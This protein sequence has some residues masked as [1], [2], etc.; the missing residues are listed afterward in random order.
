MNHSETPFVLMS[1]HEDFF[2]SL[3]NHILENTAGQAQ[4]AVVI[5]PHN[6]PKAYLIHAFREYCQEHGKACLL[7]QI[8]T[9]NDFVSLLRNAWDTENTPQRTASS[10]DL[11]ALLWH[12]VQHLKH[13]Q[14]HEHNGTFA[15]MDQVAF[16]PWSTMLANLLEE[17]L[18]QGLTPHDI[19][20]AEG[21]VTP[22]AADLLSVLEQLFHAFRSE[23]EKRALTT[24]GLNHFWIADFL[25]NNPHS[26]LPPTLCG[27]PLYLAGFHVLTGTEERLF[28]HLWRQGA[29]ICLHSDPRILT[30]P[31]HAHDACALHADWLKRWNAPCVIYGSA[32]IPEPVVPQFFVGYDLHSQLHAVQR[33]LENL[34]PQT[35]NTPTIKNPEHSTYNTPSETLTPAN[36]LDTAA[37]EQREALACAAA[38]K[39]GS[40]GGLSSPRK[41]TLET[42]NAAIVLPQSEALLPVLHH[43]PT[44][45]CNVSLGYPLHRSL[46]GRLLDAVLAVRDSTTTDGACSWSALLHVLR[47]PYLRMLHDPQHSNV[48]LQNALQ[49]MEHVLRS[50]S[51]SVHINTLLQQ[52]FAQLEAFSENAPVTLLSTTLDTLVTRWHEI[53]T[54][55]DM[56]NCLQA[57]GEHLLTY[58]GTIWEKFP[59]DAECLFRVLQHLVP[60]LRTNELADAVLPWSLLH[61]LLSDLFH[62]ERV[63]FEANPITGIQVLG[64]LETRLL[65]VK[66]VFI[67]DATDDV[68]PGT[69]ERSPLLPDNMRVLIGL[70]DPR[71][72]EQMMAYTFHRLL[73]GAEHIHIYWQ[74]GSGGTG[75]FDGRKQRSRFVELLLWRQE[76]RL[77]RVFTV[78]EAPLK[79]P[80]LDLRP[81][82]LQRTPLQ[83]TPHLHALMQ[84]KLVRPLSPTFLAA[85]VRCPLQCCYERLLKFQP[86]DEVKE[87]DDLPAVGIVL[88]DVLQAFYTPWLGKTVERDALNEHELYT[89]FQKHV[90][91]SGLLRRL[92][93]ESAVMLCEAGPW[94]LQ[95]YLGNH[96]KKTSIVHLEQTLHRQLHYHDYTWNLTGTVDRVDV[97]SEGTVILDYKSGNVRNISPKIWEH[98]FWNTLAETVKKPAELIAQLRMAEND[99]MTQCAELLPSLQLLMYCYL[100]E[101]PCNAAFVRLAEDGQEI[102]LFTD[103]IEHEQREYIQC[104]LTKNILTYILLHMEHTPYFSPRESTSCNLCSMKNLCI[105]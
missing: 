93:P 29:Q 87:K 23:L 74:E 101:K 59:L 17:C 80:Q 60:I 63:P 54:L 73:A 8:Y 56:A 5:F 40:G 78:G 4:Q 104:V 61:R 7:P 71:L 44:K 85:Y 86:M 92:P 75:L 10:L 72:R 82:L 84:K 18:T 50:G 3:R 47:H 77:G 105:I 15:D 91:E 81:P 13:D 28:Q 64:M 99:L 66:H 97:R 51:P 52:T 11:S 69:A 49:R 76:Q 34:I 96:P 36:R 42:V 2:T 26:L 62:S 67:L 58:G 30:T 19:R 102:P 89:L 98:P 41:K 79:T 6:R 27:N 32:T 22:F 57:L 55:A 24:A 70:P 25:Q 31:K 95:R 14:T 16:I 45:A 43:L 88:H 21:E 9:I 100:Y 38:T 103:E 20:Y 35:K 1:W 12:C 53:Q 39:G 37:H 48:R 94:R 83:R 90:H 46:F 68:L 65:H 33:D